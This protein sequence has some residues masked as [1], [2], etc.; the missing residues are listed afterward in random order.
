MCRPS[1]LDVPRHLEITFYDRGTGRPHA[2]CSDKWIS[3]QMNFSINMH[4]AIAATLSLSHHFLLHLLLDIHAFRSRFEW[5]PDAF[6]F[7]FFSFL[8]LMLLLMPCLVL[9]ILL[10]FFFFFLFASLNSSSSFVHALSSMGNQRCRAVFFTWEA[11]NCAVR[12][13]YIKIF[14]VTMT[15][16]TCNN[17]WSWCY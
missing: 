8:R 11:Y 7:I 16:T 12:G 3:I 9:L 1:I 5:M 2:R 14:M 13:C 10:V 4:F 6:R 15:T 17:I